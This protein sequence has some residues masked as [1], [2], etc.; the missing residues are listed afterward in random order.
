MSENN[1][2]SITGTAVSIISHAVLTLKPESVLKTTVY[3]HGSTQWIT[4]QSS[5]SEGL[6]TPLMILSLIHI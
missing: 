5:F 4:A 6:L 1:S 2:P 3:I